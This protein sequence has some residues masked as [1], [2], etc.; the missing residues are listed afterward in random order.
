MASKTSVVDFFSCGGG[1]S[2]GFSRR[3]SFEVIGAVDL[4][5][6]KPSGGAG[7]SDC[8]S[9]YAA[10]I[11]IA[12]LNRDMFSLTP[13]EFLAT[14]GKNPGDIGVMICCAPCTDLSRAK[15]TNHLVDSP[16]NGL[17]ARSAEFVTALK[18]SIVIM[19]NAREL[20]RGNFQHHHQLFK[21]RLEAAGYSVRSEIDIQSRFGLPQNRERSL[22]VASRNGV[23]RSLRE[24]WQGWRVNPVAVTVRSALDRLAEWRE[25]TPSDPTGD[26]FP[27]MTQRVYDRLAATP[28][29]GGSWVD[30]ARNE[31]TRHLLTADCLRRWNA[32]DLGSHPDIY[33]RMWLDRPAPTIKRE[34]SHLGNGRYA[35]PLQHRLLSVREMAT[36]QG[37]PFDF[38]FPA[39]SVANRYRHIGDAVPP[40]I[41]WQLS[42][43]ARW[44]LDGV[45]PEI[46]ELIM[47]LTSLRLSDVVKDE[48][49]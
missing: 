48:V 30:V 1:A 5:V 21:D 46:D 9:T 2:I 15:P 45:R 20:I 34:S 41:S 23:A 47:P 27:G 18:P 38:S 35:H 14:I 19:E 12:P 4:E 28:L 49:R 24:L 42:A 8:N 40:L 32:N 3:D 6:A 25:T 33:G 37:F 26:A 39:S 44:M 11:G 10:N 13:E 17:I 29:D 16:R 22:I 31:A 43:L 7:T 36:L